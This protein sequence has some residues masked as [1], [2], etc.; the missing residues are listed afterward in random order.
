MFNTKDNNKNII[1]ESYYSKIDFKVKYIWAKDFLNELN[2]I[3]PLLS[4]TVYGR[5]HLKLFTNCLVSWD[6]LYLQSIFYISNFDDLIKQSLCVYLR[7]NI[8]VAASGH[9][10]VHSDTE[11]EC[12]V[13]ILPGRVVGYH[14]TIG[15]NCP[16]GGGRTREQSH[17]VTRVHHQGLI[18]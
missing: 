9:L 17:W 11:R 16:G 12:P 10:P 8:T 14:H 6:T 2:C 13:I 15:Y 18:I 5:R 7:S 3:K 1:W 4:N